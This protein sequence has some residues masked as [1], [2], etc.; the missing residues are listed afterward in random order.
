MGFAKELIYWFPLP[1]RGLAIG[2]S[3]WRKLAGEL[4]VFFAFLVISELSSLARLGVYF[5][6]DYPRVYKPYFYTYWLTGSILSAVALLATLELCARLFPG[7]R[8]VSFY[9]KLFPFAAIPILGIGIVAGLIR[10]FVGSKWAIVLVRIVFGFDGI[11]VALLFFFVALMQLMGRRWKN[12]ELGIAVG[13]SVIAAQSLLTSSVLSG[14]PR[15]RSI[16]EVLGPFADDIACILWLLSIW[17]FK[18]ARAEDDG[19]LD[20]EVLKAAEDA[21]NAMKEMITRPDRR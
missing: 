9:R 13:L 3:V 12:Y 21:R 20:P 19:P 14:F 17:S 4:P 5:L 7:F 6:T 16:A 8:R 11:R 2:M 10:I 18:R 15:L 1:A